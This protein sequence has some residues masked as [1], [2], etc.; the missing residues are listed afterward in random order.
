MN[1][2][3]HSTSLILTKAS[4]VFWSDIWF[5]CMPMWMIGVS[6]CL[7][8]VCIQWC[9]EYAY[10]ARL[11]TCM[12][13][14]QGDWRSHESSTP[15]SFCCYLLHHCVTEIKTEI[16][17]KILN[18]FHSTYITKMC[19]F[20]NFFLF[21]HFFCL[22]YILGQEKTER[23]RLRNTQRK[24]SKY[25]VFRAWGHFIA[26]QKLNTV[27]LWSVFVPTIQSYLLNSSNVGKHKIIALKVR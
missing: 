21:L 20:S 7:I 3:L 23:N 6:T 9:L 1:G 27:I 15:E 25:R 4:K 8:N 17:Q 10:H 11:W 12:L 18:A 22:F 16:L 5:Y 2:Y 13:G 14:S 26:P 19:I 24:L